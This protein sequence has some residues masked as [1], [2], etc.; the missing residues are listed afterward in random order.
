MRIPQEIVNEILDHLA[1]DSDRRSLH[2]SA[3]MSKSWLPSCRQHL[4]RSILFSSS[5]TPRWVNTFPVLGKS[6]AFYIRN[7]CFL[8]EGCNGIERISKYVLWFTNVE[9]MTLMGETC[10][11]ML[12][13]PS[14][15]SLQS[16]TSLIIDGDS[17]FL[18]HI[19]DIMVHLPNLDNLSLWGPI[20][21]VNRRTLVGIRTALRGRFGGKLQLHRRSACGDTVDMLLE[22]PTGL[23]FTEVKIAGGCDYLL[24]TVR[25]TEACSETLVKLMYSTDHLCKSHPFF[26]FGMWNIDTDDTS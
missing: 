23:H 13:P 26:S 16:T 21:P 2:L 24:S 17:F 9:R 5:S 14:W 10:N 6:P 19:W 3:L 20:V 15:R 12:I 8:V 11:P 7:L 25:L 18:K 22:I 4:F 1:T